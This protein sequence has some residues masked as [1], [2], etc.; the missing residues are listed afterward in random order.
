MREE[1]YNPPIISIVSGIKGF[2]AGSLMGLGVFSAWDPVARILL[3][4]IGFFVFQI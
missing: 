4:I 3:V 2:V 1:V